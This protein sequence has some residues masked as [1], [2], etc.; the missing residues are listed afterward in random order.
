MTEELPVQR[1]FDQGVM[2]LSSDR[3][4][5]RVA[6]FCFLFLI[7]TGL[8]SGVLWSGVRTT[9]GISDTLTSISESSSG[10]R[11]SVV[12]SIL[13]GITTL[14]LAAML[15]AIV[16]RQDRNLAIL[17]LSCRAVEAGLYAVGILNTLALLS[18]SQSYSN[19]G[20]DDVSSVRVLADLLMKVRPMS[21]NI[22]A[23]FFSV[24]SA[25][26]CYLLL[27]ARSIPVPLSAI[28]LVG[29]L[30]VFVGVPLQTAFSQSTFAGV[31]ALIW[32]PIAIFE[33]SAAVW[34]LLKGARVT[35]TEHAEQGEALV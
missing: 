26:Y 27:K 31:S 19:A 4:A 15:Y 11:L 7:A 13:G 5:P 32:V 18:M 34:L 2:A 22:G 29:S 3:Y 17:A 12:L 28:G 21:S 6:G 30:L 20:A 24:G 1:S 35:A 8:L 14:V 16:A 25:F 10:I 9:G 23:I 33:I